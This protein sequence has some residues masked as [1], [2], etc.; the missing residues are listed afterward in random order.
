MVRLALSKE[1]AEGLLAGL[2][3]SPDEQVRKAA[4]QGVAT[5]A[6]IEN[7]ELVRLVSQVNAAGSD[8]R[9]RA[10]GRLQRDFNDSAEAISLALKLLDAS[11]VDKLS[12]SG[13]INVLYFLSRT[14]PRAWTPTEIAAANRVLPGVR[15]RNAG[16]QTQAE[17]GRVEDTVKAAGRQ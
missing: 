14:D 7:A 12:P 2:Q 13:L 8:E 15:A 3:Q 5:I 4:A 10:T 1:E 16:P 17:L 11:Q 9:R 6:N